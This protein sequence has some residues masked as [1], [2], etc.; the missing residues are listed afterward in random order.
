MLYRMIQ[1]G[2]AD[3]SG[4]LSVVFAQ[5]RFELLA[6]LFVAA[7]V[8][9]VGIEDK[10]VSRTHQRDL[11]DIGRVELLLPYIHR[12][13]FLTIRM[14]CGELQPERKKL[15]H[16]IDGLENRLEWFNIAAMPILVSAGGLGLAFYKRKRTAAK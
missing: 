3:V 14:I 2:F 11:G 12:V 10:N 9:S 16:D 8:D 4:L 13:V 6:R 15:R 5:N 7:V 1:Q